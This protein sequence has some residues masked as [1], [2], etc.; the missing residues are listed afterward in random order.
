LRAEI[1]KVLKE[2]ADEDRFVRGLYISIG[3]GVA[4]V[5]A[6]LVVIYTFWRGA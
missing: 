6:A 1:A 5:A 4:V 2:P 3:L